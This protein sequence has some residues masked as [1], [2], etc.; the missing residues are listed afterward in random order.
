MNLYHTAIYNIM[1]GPSGLTRKDLMSYGV[2][3]R[4]DDIGK[5]TKIQLIGRIAIRCYNEN[6]HKLY[7]AGCAYL[8]KLYL[9]RIS[10]VP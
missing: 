10:L 9:R 5:T 8:D 1:Y 2:T 3:R 4:T 7:T 6:S